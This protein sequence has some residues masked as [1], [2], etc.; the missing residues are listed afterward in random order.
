M[1]KDELL[2]LTKRLAK[3]NCEKLK[4]IIELEGEIKTLKG[5]L[6][7][8]KMEK[9]QYKKYRTRAD[10]NT[11]NAE[12]QLEAVERFAKDVINNMANGGY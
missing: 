9:E 2:K 5:S 1:T 8:H 7:F 11:G 4:K 10:Q 6:E 3:E 12:A